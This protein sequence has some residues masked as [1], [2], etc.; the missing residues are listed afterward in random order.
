MS[1]NPSTNTG[2]IQVE[3]GGS[4]K[5]K[6]TK[7]P[8]AIQQDDTQGFK[9]FTW[10]DINK[11]RDHRL[12][13]DLPQEGEHTV[14][15]SNRDNSTATI[16]R[17]NYSTK[18]KVITKK[19]HVNLY[20]INVPNSIN[21]RIQMAEIW[22][23]AKASNKDSIL[24]NKKGFILKSDTPKAVLESNL[25]TPV[26]NNKITNYTA[27]SAYNENN[28]VMTLPSSGY[29]CVISILDQQISEHL[30]DSGMEFRFCKHIISKQT[31]AP[32]HF[33]RLITEK[34]LAKGMYYKS[35]HYAVYTSGAPQPAPISCSKCLKYTHRTKD[36]DEEVKCHKSH[37]L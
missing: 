13:T 10:A 31:N 28:N 11:Q 15:H 29:F 14:P 30:K 21:S 3:H 16:N 32:T 34:I 35:R 36:C 17:T 12:V 23:S 20:Y 7:T 37:N 33:I 24:E 22:E 2:N 9:G 1:E 27:T 26:N 18:F 6:A 5:R 4:N 25:K 8:D 19:E